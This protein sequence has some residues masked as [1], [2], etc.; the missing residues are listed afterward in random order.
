M[1]N[2]A[3]RLDEM[4]LAE[5]RL[6][7]S[8]YGFSKYYLGMTLSDQP[9]R[10]VGECRDAEAGV[11]YYDIYED[12]WQKRMLDAAD[13]HRSKL[14][15]CTSNGAGKT[16]KIIPGMVLPFMALN[17]RGKVVITSGV[18]RQVREQV[19]PHL[20]AHVLKRLP[21]W[22]FSDTKISAPNGSH[23]VGFTTR[24][25]GHFEG[26]HGNPDQ[27]YKLFEHDGPLMIVV[28]EAK[29]VQRTIFDAIE[30]CTYQRLALVSSAGAPEGEF[31]ESQ[32]KA[33]GSYTACFKIPASLC[34]HADHA[35][36]L[37]LIRRRGLQDPLVRSKVFA[38][39]MV[40]ATGAIIARSLLEMLRT[41]PP[42]QRRM[43]GGNDRAYFCDFAAGG[44]ENTIGE[45]KGNLVRLAAA[46]REKDT[47]RGV[48]QFILEF[49]RLG[50]SQEEAHLIHG[51][52]DGLGRVM[53]D[54]MHE[55]GWKI[56]RWSN[57]D[58]ANRDEEYK[59]RGTEMWYE[60]AKKIEKREYILDIDDETAAQLCSRAGAPAS[61][62]RLAVESKKDLKERLGYSPD[63]AE[64]ILGAMA[65]QPISI[66][67]GFSNDPSPFEQFQEMHAGNGSMI[68][69]PAGMDAG[70]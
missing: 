59:N 40:D 33:A 57:G 20:N 32:T 30:R 7:S 46:W 43:H 18:D 42:L 13:Q 17:P 2:V 19:F 53:I 27:L 70:G 10:K 66:G 52:N 28:D 38:E 8:S 62:G 3:K 36:N 4:T 16:S 37:D 21:G 12:D 22:D 55:M 26:W 49:R 64:A 39:F 15:A 54:R 68:E 34:P 65:I 63:R 14:S 60:G 11:T 69:I 50:L 51:D 44:D 23:C 29:S 35:K 58:K 67:R 61:D 6:L 45:K 25:G 56:Q 9:R 41:N 48:G 31:Y 5:K 47:M 1:S 24:E